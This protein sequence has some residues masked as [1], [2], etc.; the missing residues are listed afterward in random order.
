M[1]QQ[2]VLYTP[3]S[4]SVRS[5]SQ[6]QCKSSAVTSVFTLPRTHLSL[7]ARLLGR[8]AADASSAP[9]TLRRPAYTPGSAIQ[10]KRSAPPPP[11]AECSART[12]ALAPAAGG[13]SRKFAVSACYIGHRFCRRLDISGGIGFMLCPQVCT[14]IQRGSPGQER[15]QGAG[16]VAG[17][18]ALQPRAAQKH[19]QPPR[20]RHHHQRCIPLAHLRMTQQASVCCFSERRRQCV[21]VCQ[22]AAWHC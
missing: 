5:V 6:A 13:S 17:E 22:T 3:A 4:L 7:A 2:A 8:S 18:G 15:T 16:G 1:L 14:S 21:H 12:P 9:S 10:A 11:G 19:V 20:R